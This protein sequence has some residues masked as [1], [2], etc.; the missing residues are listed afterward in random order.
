MKDVY[1]QATDYKEGET[2][3]EEDSAVFGDLLELSDTLRGD[4][5]KAREPLSPPTSG[6][7]VMRCSGVK[8]AMRRLCRDCKVL[9]RP[10][11]TPL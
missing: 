4:Y 1:S 10:S 7:E 6:E 3:A 5:Q 11:P 2:S 9:L 8:R